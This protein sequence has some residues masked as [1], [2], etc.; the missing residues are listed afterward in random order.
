MSASI[1]NPGQA[2][3]ATFQL[4]AKMYGVVGDGITDDTSALRSAHAAANA[5]K[6]PLSYAGLPTV[7]VQG[8]LVLSGVAPTLPGGVAIADLFTGYKAV[9]AFA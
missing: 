1:W 8:C 2:S 6:V 9:G 5:L 7:A 3:Y 4:Y